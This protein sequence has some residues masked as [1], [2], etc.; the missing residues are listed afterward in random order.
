[1][2]GTKKNFNVNLNSLIGL[3]WNIKNDYAEYNMLNVK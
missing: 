2:E 1:M 3:H